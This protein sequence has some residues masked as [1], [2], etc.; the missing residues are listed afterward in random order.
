MTEVR[1]KH[2]RD[3]AYVSWTGA[4]HCAQCRRR[5]DWIPD[6]PVL[7]PSCR[8]STRAHAAWS[9][10]SVPTDCRRSSIS[11]S[12]G[13]FILHTCKAHIV[14]ASAT[15]PL[16]IVPVFSP[17]AGVARRK[18]CATSGRDA[19]CARVTSANHSRA[20]APASAMPLE[21]NRPGST[22]ASGRNGLTSTPVLSSVPV[23]R[24]T[25]RSP[26]RPEAF[27]KRGSPCEASVCGPVGLSGWRCS[28]S[29]YSAPRR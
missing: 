10:T 6:A 15:V 28:R 12:P 23:E 14:P 22:R 11:V 3:Y 20:T 2:V 4:R 27:P 9:S 25:H 18:F 24:A 13:V 21:R 1:A 7:S 26:T 5:I 16:D 19:H 29:P 17:E 8:C